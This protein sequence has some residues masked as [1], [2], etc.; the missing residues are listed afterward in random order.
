MFVFVKPALCFVLFF[1]LFFVVFLTPR[2]GKL[3]GELR[4]GTARR[5]GDS[6]RDYLKFATD[7]KFATAMERGDVLGEGRSKTLSMLGV[8]SVWRWGLV[9]IGPRVTF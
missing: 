9:N 7:L 6:Q 5:I 8:L 3:I 2:S 1:V 4:Q